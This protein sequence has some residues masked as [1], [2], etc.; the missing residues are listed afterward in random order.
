MFGSYFADTVLASNDVSFN[1][2]LRY[3]YTLGDHSVHAVAA[4]GGS[5]RISAIVLPFP[6]L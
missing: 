2:Y 4:C 5:V 1:D 3:S 6:F